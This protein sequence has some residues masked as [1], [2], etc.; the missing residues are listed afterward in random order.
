MSK[1]K[2]FDMLYSYQKDAVTTTFTNPKGIICMPTGVGKTFCQAA[3]IQNDISMNA[4]TFRMHVINAPRIL[5]TYQLLK[6]VYWFLVQSGIEAR[7]MFVHSGGKVDEKEL[8]EM[9]VQANVDGFDIPFSEIGSGTSVQTIIDMMR[10]AKQDDLPLV[11]FSTYN[12][13]QNIEI[14]RNKFTK[15]AFTTVLND[16]AHYLVQEQFHDILSV[17]KSS[18]C[19]FFTA[20]TKHTPSDKG[21]GMNN[22]DLYGEM[23]YVMTPREAIDLGKMVRPRLHI[24]TTKGVYTTDDYDKSLNLIVKDSFYQHERILTKQKA[25]IL[26]SSRGTQEILRFLNSEEYNQLRNEGVDIYAVASTPEI[27]NQINGEQLRRQEFLK[28]LK[29]DGE[30]KDKRLIVLQFD[31]LS[32][33]IDVSGFSAI[34]PLRTLNKSKF[35]QTFGR[36]ARLNKEDRIKL[37]KGEIKADDLDKMNKPYAYVIIHNIIHTNEDDKSNLSQL[38]TELRSY[39]FKP[40]EDIISTSFV[41]GIP[42]VEQMDTLNDVLKRL[43]NVGELIEDLEGVLEDE[44]LSKLSKVDLLSE[45]FGAE[46]HYT[47]KSKLVDA[48]MYK[49][50]KGYFVTKGSQAL[51]IVTPSTSNT[52]KKLRKK[53]INEKNLLEQGKFLE[54]TEDT[55][56]KSKSGA[57]GIVLGVSSNSNI[58]WIL[59]EK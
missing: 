48:N 27:G 29:I 23:L 9:R 11:F 53:L 44:N 55:F 40:Y 6:E 36:A 4:D 20:T 22:V 31:I 24:V 49:N 10:K 42:E 43:P 41:R 13:A 28:R 17:L 25:K 47:I 21:R 52:I 37:E 33:G 7:Y 12:S 26:I 57:S 30:N 34:M 18:R 45:M 8:E 14:A 2:P 51:N 19:Y 3:M 54:F 35:L 58:N 15:Q 16:E 38:I 56:F 59:R 5:L 1:I 46:E 32:E 50:D 39:G